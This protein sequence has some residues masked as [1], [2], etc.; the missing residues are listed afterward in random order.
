MRLGLL[1][2]T[3]LLAQD[4]YTLKLDV[5]VVSVDVTVVDSNQNLV[6]RLTKDD[7]L[8]SENGKP[9]PVQFFSPVSAPYNVFLLFDSSGSTRGN[10]QF[11]QKAAEVLLENLRPQ[12][13]VALGS[14]DDN[15]RINSSWTIDRTQMAAALREVVRP[16]ESN[17]THFYEALDRTLRKEFKGTVGRR[18]VVV[19]TDGQ[20]T[21]FFYESTGG[22][23]K[24]LQSSREQRIPIFLV[25]LPSEAAAQVIFPNTRR[26]LND[27]LANMQRI[28]DN[29]GGSI[30]FSRDLDDV[31]RLYEE[32]GRRL[33]TTYNIG[34]VPSNATRD[35]SFRRIEIKTRDTSLHVTQSRGGYTAS[36]R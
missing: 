32:L 16:H 26:Y 21:P 3:L 1:L 23:K 4:P 25:A 18:A 22:L 31:I 35:G 5:P 36:P 15:F 8:V 7:F 24:V 19:L 33:G 29:S 17:E 27:V 20:D 12:D 11:M 28:V 34:Y 6:N 2:T 10:R 14:F 13:R 30:L 9:Q